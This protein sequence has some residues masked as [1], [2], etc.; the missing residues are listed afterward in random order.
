MGAG[1]ASLERMRRSGLISAVI[2]L[3]ACSAPDPGVEGLTRGQF[4]DGGSE[5]GVQGDSGKPS[6]G[7]DWGGDGQADTAP[8]SAD[9]FTGAGAY[10]SQKPATSAVTYHMNNNVGVTPGKGVDCLSC[11]KNGGAGANF[12][13]AGTIFQDKAGTMPAVD[14][15]IRVRGNDGTGY[16]GHSD[17]DGNFWFKAGT[18]SVVTP[19]LTG[20]RDSAQTALMTGNITAF[21]CN[22]CHDGNTTDPMHLP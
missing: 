16:I 19:A 22:T 7:G 5:A 18:S 17:D 21:S 13:F 6:D 9:A 15:E 2:L 10:A 3:V 12:L 14:T 20:A 4:K 1:F 8:P 11:H